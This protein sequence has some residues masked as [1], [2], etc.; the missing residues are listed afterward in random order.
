MDFITYNG[1]PNDPPGPSKN[2]SFVKGDAD[3]FQL[4]YAT[5]LSMEQMSILGFDTNL[6]N[7]GRIDNT[8]PT[9]YS[10]EQNF[11]NPFNPTTAIRFSLPERSQVELVVYDALGN[12]VETLVDAEKEAGVYEAEFNADGLSTGVY[13]YQ[14]K[15]TAFTATRKLLLMK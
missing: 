5:P 15:T 8:L 11:P 4:L 1:D 3:G 10:L 12:Y 14:I 13:F 2:W 6:V 7:V 9:G